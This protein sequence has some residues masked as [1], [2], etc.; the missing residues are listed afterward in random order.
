[1]ND[2][3]MTKNKKLI[4]W[5][6]DM[7]KMCKPEKVYWCDGTQDEYDAMIKISGGQRVAKPLN[8]DQASELFSFPI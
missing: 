8:P 6:D 1:M 4:S 5:V 2:S 7:A 3:S